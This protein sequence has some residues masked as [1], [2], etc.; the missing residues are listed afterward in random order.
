M[1]DPSF[2]ESP[3]V[4]E[5]KKGQPSTACLKDVVVGTQCS[6]LSALDNQCCSSASEVLFGLNMAKSTM[7]MD[8]NSPDV[9]HRLLPHALTEAAKNDPE[10]PWS[11]VFEHNDISKGYRT[12]T[13]GNMAMAVDFT[14]WWMYNTFGSTNQFE[15]LAYIGVSDL[16]YQIVHLAAIKCG[17][18]VGTFVAVLIESTMLTIAQLLCIS[19]RNSDAGYLSL[20]EDTSCMKFLCSS[21]LIK[22]GRHIRDLAPQLQ[23]EV[24]P[25][26]NEMLSS[27]TPEFPYKKTFAE[28]ENDPNLICH[29]SGSTGK[30][31][32]F[33]SPE[34]VTKSICK[35]IQ[36]Q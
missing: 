4:R 32:I 10:K 20:L 24:L 12:V 35:A 6:G 3:Q 25:T 30:W 13:I 28:A 19:V 34:K 26:F 33:S 16:R 15:T 31:S 18:K 11:F 5:W 7:Q 36:S 23:L 14:S 2:D 21:E 1:Q 29:T 8:K 9:G 27:A 17:Y 22:K